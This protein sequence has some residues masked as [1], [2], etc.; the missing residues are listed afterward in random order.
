MEDETDQYDG[1]SKSARKRSAL[2]AQD[3]G[4]RLVGLRDAELEALGLP[5]RLLDAIHEAK[6]LTSRLALSRQHQYLGKLMREL[7]TDAIIA[8]LESPTRAAGVEAELQRRIENWRSRLLREG[9]AGLDALLAEAPAANR[10]QLAR[11]MAVATSDR[12]GEAA[13]TT[14]SRQLFRALRALFAT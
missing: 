13:R 2:A 3:L 12:Q 14:A 7:D 6:R 8:A 4:A 10:A 1:P 11:F 9:E 5:E